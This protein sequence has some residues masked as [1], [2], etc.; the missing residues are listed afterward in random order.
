MNT[1]A[2]YIIFGLVF[3][4]TIVGAALFGDTKTVSTATLADGTIL[5]KMADDQY[6]IQRTDGS[7]GTLKLSS[8]E[9]QYNLLLEQK[10]EQLKTAGEMDAMKCN[11]QTL[12]LAKQFMYGTTDS[13]QKRDTSAIDNSISELNK[14]IITLKS[15]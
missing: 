11:E 2:F 9:Q 8:I 6:Y 7:T 1:I 3:G 15:L 13:N 14:L 4:T 5:T 12:E 10:Q